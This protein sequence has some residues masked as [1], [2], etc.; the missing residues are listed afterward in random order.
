MVPF[1]KVVVSLSVV[2]AVAVLTVHPGF[3]LKDGIFH[4]GFD[5]HVQRI[6]ADFAR[7]DFLTDSREALA[8]ETSSTHIASNSD[9]LDLICVRIC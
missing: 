8:P 3:E 6:S 2:L 9:S 1:R 7:L 4:K 5:G